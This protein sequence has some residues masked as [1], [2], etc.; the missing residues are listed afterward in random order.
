[1]NIRRFDRNINREVLGLA[2]P[3]LFGLMTEPLM[4]IIDTMLIGRYGTAELAAA[5]GVSAILST[6]I[7]VFNFLST[8]TT[9]K[10]AIFYGNAE[11]QRIGRFTNMAMLTALGISALI[12]IL[13]TFG[14]H[15]IL[16]VYGFGEELMPLA[17][18]Y[19]L[20]RLA[21]IPFT[22]LMMTGIGFF[23]GIQNARLP[24]AVAIIANIVNLLLD[25]VLIYGIEGFVPEL[26]I[27]GAAIAT[28]AGQAV[29]GLIILYYMYIHKNQRIYHF[30]LDHIPWQ[31]FPVLFRISIYLFFRTLFLLASFTFASAIA[32]RM[33]K[34]VLAGH[35]IAMKLWLLGS[36]TVDS[37]A[38][39]AQA[40][41]GR[42]YENDK[43]RVTKIVWNVSAW[44]LLLGIVFAMTYALFQSTIT[45]LFSRDPEVLVQVSRV[46]LLLL[47]MQPL[48]ALTFVHDGVLIGVERVSY[49]MRM[50][51]V[52]GIIYV[53]LSLTAYHLE[54]GIL[55]IWIG[56]TAMVAWRFTSNSYMTYKLIKIH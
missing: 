23:R 37:F 14:H 51:L 50:M 52:A 31:E 46:F 35:E 29:G 16:R 28:V 7:W 10:V 41:A 17:N 5:G 18:T 22:M 49:L 3:S 20:I 15:P 11:H 13:L 32:I 56:L 39:A 24:M 40:L 36:F 19:L 48:S 4:G 9:T 55:G 38:V 43:E 12:V 25:I 1:M 27:A 30:K 53:G 6:L 2:I 8:G 45:G 26:G 44:G 21:G 33:G 54:W 42:Y 34:V 47:L